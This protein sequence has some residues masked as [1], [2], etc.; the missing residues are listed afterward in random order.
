MKHKRRFRFS[1]LIWILLILSGMGVILAGGGI[2]ALHHPRFH[3]YVQKV[4]RER[5]GV[6]AQWESLQWSLNG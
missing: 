4:M 2:Y 5:L 6:E 3:A 1:H